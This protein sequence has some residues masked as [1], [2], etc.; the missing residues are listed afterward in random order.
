VN[1]R[2]NTYAAVDLGSNSFHLLVARRDHG[3]L[4]VIDAIKEMVR[5]GGGLDDQ[6]R[7]DDATQQRALGCLARFGQRL[8]GIPDENI[9]AV[10]TQTFRRL[11]NANA[12][13]LVTETALGCPVDIIGGREEARLVYLGVSQGVSGHE[14][15]RLVIDIGGGST[16]LVI[17]EGLVPL[18]LESLQY[19]CVSL[20]RQ[21]FG[22]GRITK[23]RWKKAV[24]SVA[25]DLQELQLRYR[26]TGWDTAVGSSGTIKAVAEIC[27][28]QGWVEKDISADA[29]IQL[30]DAL[31]SFQ[32]IEAVELPGLS[33]RRHPVIIGGLAMLMACFKALKFK[34]LRVSPY[35]LREGV[36][37]DLLGRLEHRDPRDKT[38]QAFRARYGVDTRQVDRVKKIALKA[39]EQIAD[40]MFLRPV[41]RELLSW[42]AD[43]HETG[44]S[45]SH[46]HFQLHSGYLVENSD[47][48]GFS[49]QEQLFL[50]TLIRCHRRSLPAD[51]A[52]S[53]PPRLHEPLRVTL[54]CLRFA[55]VL[56][57]SRDEA[58]I[59]AFSMNGSHNMIEAEFP[60][61]WMSTHPLTMMDLLNEAT[62]LNEIGLQFKVK[63]PE[64]LADAGFE[65][66]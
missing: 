66:I 49:R 15:R 2:A 37:H 63:M 17:G 34:T 19:G 29:V 52:Q 26:E 24:R 13:L 64:S 33:E 21:F 59:P 31:L 54:F 42:A 16:E 32:N 5:L 36:L 25:A 10:G 41:H 27:R 51:F 39:C 3:E 53:L 50:A 11:K 56:C 58:A 57:R 61:D 30:R 62:Q 60:P 43:L 18:E 46:S 48:A 47:M 22:D 35:A 7:L 1:E 55:A 12:F 14:E 28:Q 6:G 38:V 40:D 9:R 20:T 65:E 4:R 8:R 45:V 23:K 44:L